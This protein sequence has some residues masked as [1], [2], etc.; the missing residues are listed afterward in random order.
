MKKNDPIIK[1]ELGLSSEIVVMNRKSHAYDYG[2][3]VASYMAHS[4]YNHVKHNDKTSLALYDLKDSISYVES[5]FENIKKLSV[6][7]NSIL[8]QQA[9]K[10]HKFS[11]SYA[12]NFIIKNLL[13]ISKSQNFSPNDTNVFI[14]N[15]MRYFVLLK[16]AYRVSRKMNNVCQHS[17]ISDVLKQM[18]NITCI[19]PNYPNINE[20]LKEIDNLMFDDIKKHFLNQTPSVT[21]D[22]STR[23][24]ACDV[25]EKVVEQEQHLDALDN[26]LNKIEEKR[27]NSKPSFVIKNE[28]NSLKMNIAIPG[29]KHSTDNIR[30]EYKESFIPDIQSKLIIHIRN[31][32][33][34]IPFGTYEYIIPHGY[35]HMFY[36]TNKLGVYVFHFKQRKNEN[37]FK[38][39]QVF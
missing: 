10:L 35:T 23:I 20:H 38:M 19:Y 28:G 13:Q 29:I 1:R 17:D 12:Q 26:F 21:P 25:P 34:F 6:Q 27:N 24:L 36:D 15:A 4:L 7:E 37:G 5:Y 3:S 18:G 2:F 9:S 31:G 8:E 39:V 14:I 33:D 32:N 11:Y 30:I 22:T 16:H